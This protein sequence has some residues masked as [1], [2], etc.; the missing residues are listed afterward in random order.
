[1][2]VASINAR[3]SAKQRAKGPSPGSAS[4]G[5]RPALR[6]VLV[7]MAMDAIEPS[8]GTA[9]R[10]CNTSVGIYSLIMKFL[11]D[12]GHRKRARQKSFPGTARSRVHGYRLQRLGPFVPGRRVRA[13]SYT[14]KL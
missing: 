10:T 3:L 4:A 5:P 13:V 9:T 8:P 11:L 12:I 1:M 6:A 14:V 2:P 7:T